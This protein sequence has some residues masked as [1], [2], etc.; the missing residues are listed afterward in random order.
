MAD[1]ERVKQILAETGAILTGDHFLYASGLHGE[2]YVNKD[3]VYP[4]TQA[5]SELCQMI[6]ESFQ[7]RGVDVVIGPEKGGIILAQWT[8]YHL[9]KLTG[10]EV[11]GIYA[12]KEGVDGFA[13]KRGYD[14]FVPNNR[15]LFVED[16]LTTGGSVKRLVEALKPM[17][18]EIVGVGALCNRGGVTPE[19]IGGVPLESLIS[20]QMR[21]WKPEDCPMCQSDIPINRNVGHGK[22]LSRAK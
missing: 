15:L 2:A 21:S 20:L 17:G 18:G 4:H 6:A 14:R 5:T 11:L 8:A 9:S 19:D 7:H 13:L 12:E 3:S 1:V 16:V 22:N 10:R